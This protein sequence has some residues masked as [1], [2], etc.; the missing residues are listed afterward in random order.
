MN[1]KF[2]GS[3]VFFTPVLFQQVK[4]IIENQVEQFNK[5]INDKED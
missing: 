2:D 5:K 4:R 1:Y 3:K